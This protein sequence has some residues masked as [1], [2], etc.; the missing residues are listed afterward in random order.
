MGP[1]SR[2]SVPRRARVYSTSFGALERPVSEQAVV[3]NADSQPS[4]KRVQQDTDAHC[5]PG[6][7]PENGDDAQ[8]HGNEESGF[9]GLELVANGN[10]R[11]GRQRHTDLSH[12][13]TS[14]ARPGIRSKPAVFLSVDVRVPCWIQTPKEEGPG[15]TTPSPFCEAIRLASEKIIPEAGEPSHNST[16]SGGAKT[17]TR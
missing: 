7:L 8:V 5:R 4:E 9:D 3:A 13:V 14:I 1:P 11:R 15:E 10:G 6:G 2:V 16:A 17:L 12:E